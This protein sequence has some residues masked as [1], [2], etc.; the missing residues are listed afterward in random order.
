[1]PMRE[2]L[3]LVLTSTLVFGCSADGLIWMPP[4]NRADPL[5]RFISHG[6][7]GFIDSTGKIVIDPT[8]EASSN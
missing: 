1:M 6:R 5:F 7:A 2:L 4:T 8:L 3:A